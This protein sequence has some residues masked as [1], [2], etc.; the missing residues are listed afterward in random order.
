MKDPSAQ[1]AA[2]PHSEIRC[3]NCRFLY[4]VPTDTLR[5]R[6]RLRC[7]NC[8]HVFPSALHPD[9]SSPPAAES[10]TPQQQPPKSLFI[11]H[12]KEQA[13]LSAVEFSGDDEQSFFEKV[14]D[15]KLQQIFMPSPEPPPSTPSTSIPSTAAPPPSDSSKHP[16][17]HKIPD[18]TAG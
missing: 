18:G 5:S 13:Y 8:S 17:M 16:H 12:E 2:V 9:A 1:P 10:S 7:S 14:P 15:D 4:R 3:P 6:R 11:S